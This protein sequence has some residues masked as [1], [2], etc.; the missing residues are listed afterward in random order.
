MHESYSIREHYFQSRFPNGNKYNRNQL[1]QVAYMLRTE[2]SRCVRD[3]KTNK[4]LG[5]ADRKVVGT[6]SVL[7][8]LHPLSY[9][10]LGMPCQGKNTEGHISD[11]SGNLASKYSSSAWASEV[12]QLL[13]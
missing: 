11:R 3:R 12:K 1:L 5:V 8:P 10:L 7:H 2:S 6:T 4:D 13:A 9:H